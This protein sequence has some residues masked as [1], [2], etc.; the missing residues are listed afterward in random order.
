MSDNRAKTSGYRKAR[1]I[2]NGAFNI[3]GS[4]LLLLLASPFFLL[5]P[6]LIKLTDGGP[7]L[8]RSR[9][10]GLGKQPYEMYKFR[11]LRCDADRIVGSELLSERHKLETPIGSFLRD[12]R[13]DELP[14]LINVLKGDMDLIGPRPERPEIYERFCKS[15]PGYDLRFQVRPG[16]IGYA[17]VFTPHGTPK[18]L[19]SLID[20]HFVL[21]D[22][23]LARDI[24]LLGHAMMALIVRGMS[25]SRRVAV[26][27]VRRL[28]PRHIAAERRQLRRV[29]LSGSTVH[30]KSL[31]QDGGEMRCT[32]IDLNDEAMLIHCAHELE[33]AQFHVRVTRYAANARRR[34]KKLRTAHCLGKVV[35]TR[36]RNADGEVQHVLAIEPW[37]ALNEFKLQKYF[38]QTSVS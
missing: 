9:R 14:Q 36:P 24:G 37:S 38:L 23:S 25:T 6:R 16:V 3:G 31:G 15:I 29:A 22:Q 11:S 4:A 26:E 30:L 13:L 32:L 21:R 18:R 35:I 8:Y 20:T 7:V 5:I 17:Q 1:S 28:R 2:A 27:I 10:L 34:P 12:T 33:A 19:R